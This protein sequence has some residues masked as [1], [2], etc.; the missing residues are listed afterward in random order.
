MTEN[1]QAQD[2]VCYSDAD[3]AHRDVAELNL[4]CAVGLPGSEELDI[5]FCLRTLDRWAKRVRRDTEKN[6][7]QF[8]RHPESFNYSWA[9]VRILNMVTVLQRDL[10]VHYRQELIDMDD[11][12]FFSRADH[13]QEGTMRSGKGEPADP[14]PHQ[15]QPAGAAECNGKRS[16]ISDKGQSAGASKSFASVRGDSLARLQEAERKEWRTLWDDVEAL[17]Q[18]AA[19][20]PELVPS[21]KE[22]P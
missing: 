3:I 4:M 13:I 11:A 21:P 14:S 7:W 5:G 15:S 8:D 10:G 2:L 17:R 16:S 19:Q 12:G 22:E 9:F 20:P 1:L 18:R 6:T